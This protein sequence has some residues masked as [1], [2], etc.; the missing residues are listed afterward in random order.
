MFTLFLN[1]EEG[2]FVS[3][4]AA[5]VTAVSG[6]GNLQF[7]RW[8]SACRFDILSGAASLMQSQ[9]GCGGYMCWLADQKPII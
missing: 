8:T 9:H 3:F 4:Q 7:Q 6:L 1:F 2:C 5:H